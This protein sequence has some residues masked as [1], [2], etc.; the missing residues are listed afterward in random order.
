MGYCK[1]SHLFVA[2][3]PDQLVHVG[4][5]LARDCLLWLESTGTCR[6]LALGLEVVETAPDT[7]RT[8][9]ENPIQAVEE[10]VVGGMVNRSP[11]VAEWRT[12]LAVVSA[13]ASTCGD[14]CWWL[15]SWKGKIA[16]EPE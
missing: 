8:R 12:I 6:R 1:V 15:E 11:R 4:I 10:E 5:Q 14:R 16:Q 9:L 7:R 3:L 13:E 2:P